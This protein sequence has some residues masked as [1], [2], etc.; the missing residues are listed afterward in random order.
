MR[1]A[2][3]MAAAIVV[4]A[5]VLLLPQLMLKQPVFSGADS[6]TFYVGSQSSNAEM[7]QANAANAALIKLGLGEV[8]GESAHYADAQ[9]AFD[10]A[11]SLGARLCGIERAGDVTN[12][13][14]RTAR[15]RG[16]VDVGGACV[17]LHIAV[18]GAG[19]CIG[20]PLVFGGY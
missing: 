4:C 15:L 9:D 16:G 19:A 13:Y 10:I 6:Y 12:Y 18:R 7:V 8:A 17:N 11:A 3:A 2:L 5:A 20:T 1:K 14:Y